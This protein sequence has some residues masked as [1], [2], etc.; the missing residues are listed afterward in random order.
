M[1][2]SLLIRNL[3]IKDF[4]VTLLVVCSADHIQWFSPGAT[5]GKVC[6]HRRG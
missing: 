5:N 6:Q 4:P 3:M 2:V 1:H